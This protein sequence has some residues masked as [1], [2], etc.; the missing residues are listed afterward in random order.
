MEGFS[1]IWMIV[2]GDAVAEREMSYLLGSTPWQGKINQ[3]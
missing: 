1:I 2:Y 3:R